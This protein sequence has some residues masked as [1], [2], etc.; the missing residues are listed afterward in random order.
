MTTITADGVREK[1]AIITLFEAASFIDMFGFEDIERIDN[2][3]T[4]LIELTIH[5]FLGILGCTDHIT[6]F[7]V[8]RP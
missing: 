4:T 3:G 6:I 2:I 7:A 1:M 5:T 8:A